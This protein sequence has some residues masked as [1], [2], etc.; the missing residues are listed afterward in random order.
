MNH[1]IQRLP[2][3]SFLVGTLSL[4]AMMA[5]EPETISGG[6]T[7]T[8]TPSPVNPPG[9]GDPS[10]GT[11][12]PGAPP[13]DTAAPV[14]SLGFF[15]QL[16]DRKDVMPYWEHQGGPTQTHDFDSKCVVATDET[17]PSKLDI[18]CTVDAMEEDVFYNGVDFQL[19]VPS[20]MC[21]FV[22]HQLY[23][24]FRAPAG[25]GNPNIQYD[26]DA[27]GSL[28]YDTNNDGVINTTIAARAAADLAIPYSSGPWTALD[29]DGAG[30]PAC[31]WDYTHLVP[32]G[33]NCCEGSYTSRIRTWDTTLTTP[34]YVSRTTTGDWGGKASNCLAGP[35][36]DDALGRNGWP[37]IHVNKVDGVGLNTKLTLSTP[38]EKVNHIPSANGPVIGT[39][40]VAN[41]Y[42]STDHSTNNTR[43]VPIA[44]TYKNPLSAFPNSVYSNGQGEAYWAECRDQASELKARI[45]VYVREWNTY[46][47]F[48]LKAAGDPNVGGFESTPF[49][50]YPNNDWMDWQDLSPNVLPSIAAGEAS[51]KGY[52]TFFLGEN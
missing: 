22:H 11:T 42:N 50:Q 51:F 46:N 33:P 39:H 9:T 1:S 45:R 41:Y 43:A 34:A 20:K 32:P 3:V 30:Q 17:S 40:Y 4:M 10:G 24:Y 44:F 48:Q 25:V 36:V 49:G 29:I 13:P 14:D 16:V 2:K 37:L 6:G 52:F 8:P 19:H 15:V 26:V 27:N 18:Q 23:Y 21:T 5:C 28:G 7:A 12:V 47:Q 31:R 35:A 38:I